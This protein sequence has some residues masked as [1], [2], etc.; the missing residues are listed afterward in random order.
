VLGELS[1]IPL[2]TSE[3]RLRPFVAALAAS[4]FVINREEV[5]EVLEL[6]LCDW[7]SRP[8]I[9]AIPWHHDGRVHLSPVFEIGTAL[10][11]GAT[12]HVFH[13]LLTVAAPLFGLGVPALEPGRYQWQDV[14]VL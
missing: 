4:E 9:H 12:A 6:P 10:M 1:S 5:S 2:Y 11:F 7:L 8:M 3:Y 13:E 14:L